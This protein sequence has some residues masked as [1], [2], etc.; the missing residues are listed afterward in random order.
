M[1]RE[2][3]RF[4]E[5]YGR[6]QPFFLIAS[7]LKPHAPFTP[8][9]RFVDENWKQTMKLP[10][11][12]GKVDPAT[13]PKYIQQRM[14]MHPQLKDPEKAKLR[15]AMQN[16]CVNQMDHCVGEVLKGLQAAGLEDDTIVVYTADHGEM[17][18]EHGLW[19]KFVFYEASAGVPLLVKAPG[20]TKAG[21]VSKAP[22][23][24]LSLLPTLME[25]CGLDAPNDVDEPS[26]VPFLRDAGRRQE[27]A[28]YSEFSM[29]G[30]AEKY[31]MRRGHWKYC[32]YMGDS[33]EL[34]NLEQDPLEM[35]NLVSETKYKDVAAKMQK[36]VL[37]WRHA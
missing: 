24:Q 17:R 26:L 8:V 36:D 19:D 2:S 33:D 18:G 4:V 10:E 6:K 31:M 1:A 21:A 20:V 29:G 16:A 15:L 37:E 34:Y 12:W 35:H 3:V 23:S 32:Y 14:S 13:V 25:L 28:V 5:Q 11:T 27:R 7:F 22:V 30:Q 9:P